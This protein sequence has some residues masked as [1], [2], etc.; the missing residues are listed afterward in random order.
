MA[1]RKLIVRVK[2]GT[3]WKRMV[4]EVW[5]GRGGSRDHYAASNEIADMRLFDEDPGKSP[6]Q[7]NGSPPPRLP[8]ESEPNA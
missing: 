5:T 1:M 7:E 6:S 4:P 8:D 2:V 3:A